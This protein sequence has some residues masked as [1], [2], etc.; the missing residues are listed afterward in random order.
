M[1]KIGKASVAI[2]APRSDDPRGVEVIAVALGDDQR[3]AGGPRTWVNAEHADTHLNPYSPANNS[4]LMSKFAHTFCT[5]SWSSN[6]S[7]KRIICCAFLPSSRVV[8]D[9]S[10]SI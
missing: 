4:S 6:A 10:I 5:S 7:I 3:P 9:G 2:I 1:R 8:L